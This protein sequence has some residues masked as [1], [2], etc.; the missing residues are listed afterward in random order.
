MDIKR[1][2][3]S[4]KAHVKDAQPED[5]VREKDDTL[6]KIGNVSALAGLLDNIR[7]AYDMISDTITG[8]Y[9]GI[10]KSTLTLL[11]GG[12]AYLA[13]PL[14][15]V[16]DFIPVAGWMDDATVLA[17]IFKRCNDEIQL[18]R[19]FTKRDS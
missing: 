4:Y 14:D 15:L 18:Y 19:D 1:I 10:A 16:P 7:V 11:V 8:K 3:N 6:N 2:L 12:L 13:L 5:V 17:W 9:K